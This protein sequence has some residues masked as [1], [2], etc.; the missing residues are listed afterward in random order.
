MRE[1]VVLGAGNIGRGLLGEIAAREGLMGNPFPPDDYHATR[2]WERVDDW[3]YETVFDAP[4]VGAGAP[5]TGAGPRPRDEIDLLFEGI[6]TIADVWLNDELVLHAE[7]MLVSH[8]VSVTERL[9][10]RANTLRVR[11][12]SAELHARRY[13]YD[14]FQYSRG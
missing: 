1:I 13:R 14:A 10:P 5:G 3:V 7:N 12:Y 11:I 8:A 6:D 4:A 2:E 9:R